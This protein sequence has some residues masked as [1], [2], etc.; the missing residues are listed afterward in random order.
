M[1]VS[2]AFYGRIASIRKLFLLVLMYLS[3]SYPVINFDEVLV[4]QLLK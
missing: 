2:S 3:K 4:N 1:G